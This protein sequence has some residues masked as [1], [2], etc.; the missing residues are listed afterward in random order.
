MGIGGLGTVA[1]GGLLLLLRLV[2][3]GGRGLSVGPWTCFSAGGL[4]RLGTRF[5]GGLIGRILLAG[6]ATGLAGAG[7]G[8]FAAIVGLCLGAGAAGAWLRSL[9]SAT[10]FASSGTVAP[11]FALRLGRL[12][13]AGGLGGVLAGLVLGRAV[14]DGFHWAGL[15]RLLRMG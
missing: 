14:A 11:A 3:R 6:L 10:L 2:R 1:A 9:L 15:L 8:G 12:W 4:S 7:F 5:P 13:R